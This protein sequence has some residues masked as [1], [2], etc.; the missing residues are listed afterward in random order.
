MIKFG[1]G[2]RDPHAVRGDCPLASAGWAQH[3]G[4]RAAKPTRAI[5]RLLLV[6]RQVGRS[7]VLSSRPLNFPP[8]FQ[9][10]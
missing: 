8:P 2:H 1:P 9:A 6:A 4:K 5:Q 10:C 3:K 7:L